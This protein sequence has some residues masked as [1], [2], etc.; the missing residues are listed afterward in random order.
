MFPPCVGFCLLTPRIA[1]KLT[2]CKQRCP[3]RHA[4]AHLAVTQQRAR[5]VRA[6]ERGQ[7]DPTLPPA[8]LAGKDASATALRRSL[9]VNVRQNRLRLERHLI[10]ISVHLRSLHLLHKIGDVIRDAKKMLL[11]LAITRLARHLKLIVLVV[12]LN[13][14]QALTLP[15]LP[16]RDSCELGLLKPQH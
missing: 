6:R 2:P 14:T 5:G 7:T 1:R 10:V 13:R 12:L 3:A 9:Q 4:Y 16:L 11:V 15:Q 8:T